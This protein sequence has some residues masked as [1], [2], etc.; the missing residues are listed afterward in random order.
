MKKIAG[1]AQERI[2]NHKIEN[3]LGCPPNYPVSLKQIANAKAWQ[4]YALEIDLINV[5]K[6][7]VGLCSVSY[8]DEIN[9]QM[10]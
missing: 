5:P 6:I 9:E 8:T 7:D 3:I 10:K 4:I 2:F 1:N